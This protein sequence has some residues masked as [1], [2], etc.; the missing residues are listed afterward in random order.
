MAQELQIRGR[1]AALQCDRVMDQLLTD[2][3]V[4]GEIRTAFLVAFEIG[5]PMFFFNLK[6]PQRG[7]VSAYERDP[8]LA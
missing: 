6:I 4:S 5:E 7:H 2:A 1:D 8:Q 3:K